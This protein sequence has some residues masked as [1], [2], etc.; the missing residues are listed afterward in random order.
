MYKL[1]SVKM[2]HS[3]LL[4][5]L[6][7]DILSLLI[8]MIYINSFFSVLIKKTFILIGIKYL[9]FERPYICLLRISG[10]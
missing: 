6:I 8:F 10:E 4:F 7:I 2:Q 5:L 9:D 1:S 3:S